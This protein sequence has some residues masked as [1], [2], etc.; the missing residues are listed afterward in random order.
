MSGVGYLGSVA[1][2][3]VLQAVDA[4]SDDEMQ[5]PKKEDKSPAVP[6]VKAKAKAKSTTKSKGKSSKGTKE[7]E[8]SHE[9]EQEDDEKEEE[10]VI[11]KKKPSASV[12]TKGMKRPAAAPKKP[13]K[14]AKRVKVYKYMYQATKTYGFKVDKK[15]VMTVTSHQIR[16]VFKL[17]NVTW[18]ILKLFSQFSRPGPTLP[19]Q[20]LRVF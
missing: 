10:E 18:N 2:A 14:E 1:A 5:N 19:H 16:Q 13:E 3:M 12:S 17:M 20:L 11:P 8:A 4:L 9:A 15:Q 6:N 7:D